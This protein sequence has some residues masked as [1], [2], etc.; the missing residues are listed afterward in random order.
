M[1]SKYFQLESFGGCQCFRVRY[2]DIFRQWI[3]VQKK[4]FVTAEADKKDRWKCSVR[5]SVW[6][7]ERWRTIPTH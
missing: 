6:V 2:F 5:V 4:T 1:T 3:P 7:C